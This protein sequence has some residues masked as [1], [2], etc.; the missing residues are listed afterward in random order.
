[1]VVISPL[2][3]YARVAADGGGVELVIVDDR[4]GQRE[5]MVYPLHRDKA[6]SLG[7]DLTTM[8]WHARLQGTP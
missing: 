8:G 2:I 3:V 6:V 5:V 4:Q 7:I 1:M